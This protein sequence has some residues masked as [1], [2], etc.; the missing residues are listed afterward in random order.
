MKGYFFTNPAGNF[1]FT[2]EIL[3]VNLPL[4]QEI[5]MIF[6][7]AEALTSAF[8]TTTG[9]SCCNFTFSSPTLRVKIMQENPKEV[10]AET[11]PEAVKPVEVAASAVKPATPKKSISI[12]CTKGKPSKKVTGANPKCPTGY[13]K[14]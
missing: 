9:A 6:L 13:P 4:E 14:R 8:A 3:R 12:T 11:K 2:P 10:V 5:M 1:G 7:E